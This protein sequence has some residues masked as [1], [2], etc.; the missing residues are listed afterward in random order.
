MTNNSLGLQRYAQETS[1]DLGLRAQT[2]TPTHDL[3]LTARA[4]NNDLGLQ[5]PTNRQSDLG[6][7]APEPVVNNG[8]VLNNTES[9]H[10]A[11]AF[12]RLEDLLSAEGYQ[13]LAD[14]VNSLQEIYEEG[15]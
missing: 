2:P 6:L 1:N 12:D 9:D 4:A 15:L 10:V 14:T 8:F 3:G 5:A 11:E 13:N 7:R